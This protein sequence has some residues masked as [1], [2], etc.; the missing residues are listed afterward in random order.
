M[1]LSAAHRD[2]ARRAAEESAVLLKNDGTLPFSKDIKKLALIGP[3]ADD[4]IILGSWAI[5]GKYDECVT[6]KEG[7]ENLIKNTEIRIAHGC[8]NLI[9]D[10]DKS[11]FDEAIEI[12]KSADAV[13][14]CI[15]EHENYSG[16]SECRTDIR[17]PG[18]QAELVKA[19]CEANKNTAVVLFC[20]RPLD[21]SNIYGAAPA[22][23]NIWFPGNEGG[24][25]VANLVFGE[26]NPSG[27]LPMSFPKAVGQC[28]VY[29]NRTNS[30]RPKENQDVPN[31]VFQCRTGYLDCGNLPLFFFGEGHSYTEFKY[32][33]M[34]LNK[35]EITKDDTLNVTVT[36]TNVGKMRGKEVV[37]LYLRDMVS[38][39]VRPIQELI[40]FKKVEL[41]AGESREVRF[42]I[43]E[44][45]LRFF[46]AECNFISEPGEFSLFV[47]YA[48]HPYLSDKFR[49][50]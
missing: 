11:G 14:L 24:N 36:L 17:L 41:D 47:G 49:L 33:K 39:A 31:T 19:I 30:G 38:S 26:A 3:F 25:A 13:L 46:D 29:Y 20:G 43:T 16:E 42:E 18:V 7:V 4:N 40:A 28:P 5:T 1:Y 21:L 22:I 23:L 45:M 27:K 9:T 12:A 44:P 15:G 50:K 2:I 35:S 37:Q 10:T 48:D 6:V 8:G 32:E 34:T